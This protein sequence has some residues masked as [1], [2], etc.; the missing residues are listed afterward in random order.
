MIFIVVGRVECFAAS[1]GGLWWV[2]CFGVV[3]TATGLQSR[4]FSLDGF[5]LG[6]GAS[7]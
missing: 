1:G 4:C 3:R 2:G 5:M 7:L 6:L